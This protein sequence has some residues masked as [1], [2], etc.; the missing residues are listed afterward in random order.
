MN[1][2]VFT[3]WYTVII[4]GHDERPLAKFFRELDSNLKND[5]Y[6]VAH[7]D[8]NGS[9]MITYRDKD[10]KVILPLSSQESLIT[11]EYTPL[12]F[13][14]LCL[15]DAEARYNDE[16]L[17]QEVR[18]VKIREINKSV[19]DNLETLEDYELYAGSLEQ[20]LKTVKTAEEENT[21]NTKIANLNR[22]INDM[23]KK[24]KQK[25]ENPLNLSLYVNRFIYEIIE[26]AKALPMEDRV[27][28]HEMIKGIILDYQKIIEE[29]NKRKESDL[30]VGDPTIPFEILYRIF[31]VEALIAKK[32]KVA[33]FR[34][35]VTN[36]LQGI[37][38]NLQAII[39]R[40]AA[41]GR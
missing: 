23:R 9:F 35:Q 7:Y 15:A 21:I 12:V 28:P 38:N 32:G 24:E 30:I 8:I 36:S 6:G 41:N 3:D 40:G 1:T 14:L 5:D 17:R 39:Q 34:N 20:E 11:K 27:E 13:K 26:K 4:N 37:E 10:Y 33:A 31:D 16:K 29:Y 2:I 22:I 19:Y 18:K 25:V